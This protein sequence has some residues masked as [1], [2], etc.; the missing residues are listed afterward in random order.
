MT[1][2][3]AAVYVQSHDS[4]H[5]F[6]LEVALVTIFGLDHQSISRRD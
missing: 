4:D 2:M 5:M 6:A 1:E 3:R